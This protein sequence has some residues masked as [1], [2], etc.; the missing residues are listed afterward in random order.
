MPFFP[1]MLDI[2]GKMCV[3]IGAGKIA[4]GKIEG[5]LSYGA[6]ITVV[7]PKAVREIKARGKSGLL[8]WHPR[9]FSPKDVN[10]AFI[11][12]AATNSPDVNAAVFRACRAK[13]IFCNSVDDPPHCDFYYPAIVRRG[14]LQIAISTNGHS[15]ALASRLRKQLAKQFGSEWGAWVEHLGKSRLD[16]LRQKL[17]PAKRRSRLLKLASPQAFRE[18]TTK[19]KARKS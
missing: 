14:P 16:I 6:R 5:L 8:A 1:I 9:R 17:P 15:P 18:F 19:R 3:V 13:G 10:G 11:V 12:I 4:A 2:S 7:A